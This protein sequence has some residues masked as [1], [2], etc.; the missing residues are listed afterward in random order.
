MLA[1]SSVTVT[2]NDDR[3]DVLAKS[4]IVLQ[5]GQAEIVLDGGDI[6][7]KCP[8]TFTVKAGQVPMKGGA[9]AT[10]QLPVLPRR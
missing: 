2:A 4:R 7:F 9:G 8:G 3:I 6:T 5:A 1:D 10:V